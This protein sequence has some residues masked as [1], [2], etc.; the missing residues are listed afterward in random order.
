MLIL[1]DGESSVRK[2][3]DM[4]HFLIIHMKNKG[5]YIMVYTDGRHQ[6]CVLFFLLNDR[7]HKIVSKK[8]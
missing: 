5:W 3:T 4:K 1:I 2:Q 7:L 6:L 8:M